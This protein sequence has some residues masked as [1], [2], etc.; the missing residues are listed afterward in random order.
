MEISVVVLYGDEKISD[1]DIGIQ[2]FL[3]LAGKRLLGSLPFVYLAAGKFPP[4]LIFT[5]AA[6]G[7]QDLS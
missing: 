1:R 5:I 3:D 7:R 6:L 4:V 2:F